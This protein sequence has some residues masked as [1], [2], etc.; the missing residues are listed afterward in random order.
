VV[1]FLVGTAAALYVP[2]W[3]SERVRANEDLA[4]RTLQ[5]L[6]SL[7]KGFQSK[8]ILDADKDGV[9][10]FGLL[11]EVLGEFSNRISPLPPK[12]EAVPRQLLFRSTGVLVRDGYCFTVYLP[13]RD[14]GVVHETTSEDASANDAERYW[15]AYAWPKWHG[16]TGRRVF[17]LDA[18]GTIRAMSNDV[19]S[20]SDEND[21]P[22]AELYLPEKSF[23]SP[24]RARG[25]EW[26]RRIR[27][28][29]VRVPPV[30]PEAP[31]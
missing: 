23:F 1:L 5:T 3:A 16:K 28:T 13:A 14:G 31:R 29:E 6:L 22:P 17:V 8:G 30:A 25:G 18:H 9:G 10:E 2:R 27:W 4:V 24:F 7:E 21:L 11:G 12:S 20:F 15:I 19:D 26:S